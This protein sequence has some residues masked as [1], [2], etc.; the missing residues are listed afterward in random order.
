[1]ICVVSFY[2][3][4]AGIKL[5]AWSYVVGTALCVCFWWTLLPPMSSTL[6]RALLKTFDVW[7]LLVYLFTAGVCGALTVSDSAAAAFLVFVMTSIG[8]V[9]ALTDALPSRFRRAMQRLALLAVAV[10]TAVPVVA[11][12]RGELSGVTDVVIEHQGVTW[13]AGT[14]FINCCATAALY[15]FRFFLTAWRR[16]RDLALMRS[17]MR[18]AKLTRAEAELHSAHEERIADLIS[19]HEAADRAERRTRKGA[20]EE[21]KRGYV[22]RVGVAAA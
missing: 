11:A 13:S 22:S 20:A 10:V 21:Q 19:R 8:P 9:A 14:Q 12:L 7:V 16:P 4:V 17:R 1:V 3:G 2:A 5:P 18:A 15:Y 6:L